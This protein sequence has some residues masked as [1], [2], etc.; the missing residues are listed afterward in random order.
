MPFIA[1][2]VFIYNIPYKKTALRIGKFNFEI[3]FPVNRQSHIFYILVKQALKNSVRYICTALE[4]CLGKK[5]FCISEIEFFL[6]K[7]FKF[8]AENRF[9]EFIVLRNLELINITVEN[10]ILPENLLEVVSALILFH[11]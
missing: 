9:K 5:L 3:V 2:S 1:K 8:P 10:I 7:I 11:H 6:N 4:Q